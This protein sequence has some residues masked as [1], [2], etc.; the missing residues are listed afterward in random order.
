MAGDEQEYLGAG[1]NGYVSKPIRPVELFQK[2][3]EVC[4]S[5]LEPETSP[6][7]ATLAVSSGRPS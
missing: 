2:L 3:S 5:R 4:G 1:M 7:A 6:S